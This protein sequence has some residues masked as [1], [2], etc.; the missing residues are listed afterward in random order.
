MWVIKFSCGGCLV[1]IVLIVFLLRLAEHITYVHQHN[2]HP[3]TQYMPLDMNLMRYSRKSG[4]SVPCLSGFFF[5]V[6]AFIFV[7]GWM[8]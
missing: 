6:V 8:S 7:P 3:P 1:L 2:S 4:E 5:L